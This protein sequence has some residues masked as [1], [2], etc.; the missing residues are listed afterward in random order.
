MAAFWQ[1][2]GR[3]NALP[4]LHPA[5]PRS[6]RARTSRRPSPMFR[7][8][9]GDVVLSRGPEHDGDTG[10]R[11]V[12]CGGDRVERQVRRPQPEH[13][14]RRYPSRHD[15]LL[16]L[17]Y[18]YGV[19]S[20]RAADRWGAGAS[21]TQARRGRYRRAITTFLD[22]GTE[23]RYGRYG[24]R[25]LLSWP[26]IRTSIRVRKRVSALYEHYSPKGNRSSGK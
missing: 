1:G 19:L 6:S 21:G 7:L 22:G 18:L 20:V 13:L 9:P 24:E 17:D 10:L 4:G 14:T 26:T 11:R 3:P 23:A 25:R 8:L 16:S 15:P 12:K 5:P 2:R